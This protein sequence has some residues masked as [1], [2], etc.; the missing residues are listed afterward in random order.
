V[1]HRVGVR[2][3][4]PY[5][6]FV[7]SPRILQHF[8]IVADRQRLLDG[9]LAIEIHFDDGYRDIFAA[10]IS[11]AKTLGLNVTAFVPTAFANDGRPYLW[12]RLHTAL[13][14]SIP[15]SRLIALLASEMETR[16]RSSDVLYHHAVDRCRT[17]PDFSARVGVLLDTL[18][19]GIK[20]TD[21][22][23]TVAEMKTM[24]Q[25]G[26]QFGLHGHTHRSF[27]YLNEGQ[28]REELDQ[29][30]A[31]FGNFADTPPRSF[32]F[33]YGSRADLNDMAA[34][35]L[36]ERGVQKLYSMLPCE[37]RLGPVAISPRW[38]VSNLDGIAFRLQLDALVG[39]A[40][41]SEEDRANSGFLMRTKRA[42]AIAERGVT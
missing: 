26:V 40:F 35:A 36:Q 2:G 11:A 3:V 25:A 29:S 9:A 18:G 8:E 38:Q 33:P 5:E 4:D 28:W 7:S 21:S 41:G 37:L 24:A 22:P 19:I 23:L 17:S 15:D 39:A 32:A 34:A 20:S 10:A 1:Y 12:D 42:H 16:D 13:M 14:V 30:F 31:G 27:G 6:L